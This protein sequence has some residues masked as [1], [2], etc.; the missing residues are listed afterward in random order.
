M[1]KAYLNNLIGLLKKEIKTI[2]FTDLLLATEEASTFK[3]IQ[4]F[5]TKYPQTPY[6]RY[7][8]NQWLIKTVK[9]RQ[10]DLS[11]LVTKLQR[12]C[13]TEWS[14]LLNVRNPD[15]I[16]E[17]VIEKHGVFVFSPEASSYPDD[18]KPLA[19]LAIT[20]LSEQ[21]GPRFKTKPEKPF[22]IF[23]DEF[24]NLAYPRFIDFINKCRE[25]QFNLILAHQANG[26]LLGISRP[27]LEQVMNT[28][29]N[30]IVLCLDDP[31][32]AEYFAR[33]FGTEED[34]DY[35]VYSYK[36]DGTMSGFTM[37]MVE[38]FRFHPNLIK[39]LQEGEAVV[40]IVGKGGVYI[41]QTK[42]GLAL[43]VP[44]DFIPSWDSS[45]QN[46]PN[47]GDEGTLAQLIKPDPKG[48][49]P[50]NKDRILGDENVA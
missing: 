2:T 20:H 10:E 35:K 12:Y 4:W 31:E 16:M 18:A 45:N 14:H 40:R 26:D 19:I 1:A 39:N 23:L 41:F 21:V 32:S 42:L 13:N 46:N 49:I 8:E 25:G 15:I 30:K 37:P 22:R 11:G 50:E 27:F 33:Q 36:S 43:P 47:R 9:Q 17:E 34:K 29:R 3:I 6:A 38:K 7:F 28:A 44:E 48:P 5:C 24:H